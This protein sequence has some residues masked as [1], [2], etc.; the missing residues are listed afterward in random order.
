ME[1]DLSS[2]LLESHVCTHLWPWVQALLAA[3]HAPTLARFD[4][5]AHILTLEYAR[6]AQ[7][8]WQALMQ[9]AHAAGLECKADSAICRHCWQS[10]SIVD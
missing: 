4:I 1:R 7:A 5:K 2:D 9:P 3:G 8:A 10:L 6:C